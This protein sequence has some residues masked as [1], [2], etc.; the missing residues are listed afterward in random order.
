MRN[1]TSVKAFYEI[2]SYDFQN[3]MSETVKREIEDRKKE[4]I[5]GV[6]EEEYK[7]YLI[8]R[9]SLEPIVINYDSEFIDEPVISKELVEDRVFGR[10]SRPQETYTFIIS[11]SFT[12]SHVVFKIQP[13]TWR[14]VT[15]D[16]YIDIEKCS[17]SF[18]LKIYQKDPEEF[19][20][21]KKDLINSAFSN[22][23]GANV[24]VQRWNNN[25]QNLVN[26]LFQRQKEKFL[27]ENNFFSAINVKV[28]KNTESI[29]TAPTVKKKIIPQPPTSKKV[30]FAS[31]PQMNK[32]MYD[33]ILK[34]I[35]D[36][37]KN[38]EK[39][40]ALYIGK[41]EEGLRDQ[42]LFI[43]ETRY[44][45]V[46]ATGETFNR[47]GKTDI[48]LKYANDGSNLFVAE[49]KFW[50]GSSE[51][52]K[53]ISQLFDKYLTWRD[54][55]VA[56]IMFVTNQDFAKVLDIIKADIK[57]HSYYIKEHGN[58]GE[59]S[60]S[61]IFRLPQDKDKHV[62]LEILVFHYDKKPV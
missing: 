22:L 58:R 16:L 38:M 23:E 32:E 26:T 1:N 35:Y 18:K 42:F 10:G 17:V 2:N 33:D 11:Y 12:G 50:H 39:K 30:E 7:K 6:D 45:S 43:L 53:A 13:D 3:M 40:P 54:S 36:A 27:Q 47:D 34:V 19:V 5:L 59:S 15:L 51:F 14:M 46:T 52:L 29:F 57:N 9:F 28:N 41:D 20:R 8:E 37:G 21:Y 44:E 48:I 31:Y 4:Y 62:F 56:V 61:Y 24:V 25:L 60:F 49:C 55:K